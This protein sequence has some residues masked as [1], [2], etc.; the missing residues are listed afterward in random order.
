MCES[1]PERSLAPACSA[2]NSVESR[3]T[4]CNTRSP[5]GSREKELGD[6]P[7]PEG[8]NAL[9]LGKC[10][11]IPRLTIVPIRRAGTDGWWSEIEAECRHKSSGE[12]EI[13]SKTTMI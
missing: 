10:L 11:R 9:I 6:R 12:N 1:E 2:A 13:D 4:D 3:T 7:A 5:K 8:R